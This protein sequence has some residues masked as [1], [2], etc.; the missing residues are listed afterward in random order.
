M[1][2]FEFIFITAWTAL[3]VLGIGVMIWFLYHL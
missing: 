1:T 2:K 3:S